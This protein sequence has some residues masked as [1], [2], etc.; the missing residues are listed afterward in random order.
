MKGRALGLFSCS[1]L[2]TVAELG[3]REDLKL[4]TRWELEVKSDSP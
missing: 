1:S 4:T 3:L 2:H